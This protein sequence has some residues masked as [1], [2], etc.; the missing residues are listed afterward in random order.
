MTKAERQAQSAGRLL[1]RALLAIEAYDGDPDDILEEARIALS[2]K[3]PGR[4][5]AGL[6][7]DVLDDFFSD[8]PWPGTG[9]GT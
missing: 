1:A 2:G 7:L 6:T 5:G 4:E 8:H 3:Q 9:A